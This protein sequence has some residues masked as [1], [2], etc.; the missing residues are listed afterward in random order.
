MVLHRREL[1]L[2]LIFTY[3]V[4]I[5]TEAESHP[6]KS[7]NGGRSGHPCKKYSNSFSRFH[8][9]LRSQEQNEF[10][11]IHYPV[12]FAE[13]MAK[14]INSS[15]INAATAQSKEL[16]PSFRS[17]KPCIEYLLVRHCTTLW[18]SKKIQEGDTIRL[19]SF[20]D[21]TAINVRQ[22]EAPLSPA[23]KLTRQLLHAHD[24]SQQRV[25]RT[26]SKDAVSALRSQPQTIRFGAPS[27]FSATGIFKGYV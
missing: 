3:P 9:V 13:Y 22:V 18:A 17:W 23:R 6:F 26:A 14:W 5:C 19:A 25:S 7:R 16:L 20:K 4:A 24:T 21:L 12:Y 8:V 11:A 15:K 2:Q 10:G 1:L 27:S